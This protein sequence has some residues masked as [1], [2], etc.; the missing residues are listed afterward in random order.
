MCT[1]QLWGGVLDDVT[2]DVPHQTA[3]L[4]ISATHAG[5]S[6]RHV[7]CLGGILELRF[8]NSIEGPWDYA[9]ITEVHFRQ[10]ISTKVWAFEFILWSEDAGLSGRCSSVTLDG[11]ELVLDT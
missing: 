7:L 2:L 8:F 11:A 1:D 9:E 3:T 10:D 6:V 4:T 5:H